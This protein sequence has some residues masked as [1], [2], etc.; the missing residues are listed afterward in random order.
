M[1]HGLALSLHQKYP[2][3]HKDYHHWCNQ[4]HS[5]PGEAWM[6]GGAEGARIV[7]LLT[8]EATHNGHPGKAS[9]KNVRHSLRELVAIANTESFKSIAISR[10]ATGAGGLDWKDVW[11]VLSEELGK[12]SIPVYVYSEFHAGM[13]AKE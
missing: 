4:H 9:I 5:K 3:M 10:L 1:N 13:K 11:P 12:L 7:N 8:Q 6:W 2:A